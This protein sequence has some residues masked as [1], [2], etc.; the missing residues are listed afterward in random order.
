[1]GSS[2]FFLDANPAGNLGWISSTPDLL[3][4]ETTSIQSTDQ[5]LGSLA[6]GNPFSSSWSTFCVEGYNYL[7]AYSLPG[8]ANPRRLSGG[9]S[10]ISTVMPTAAT[11][12]QPTLSPVQQVSV[13]GQPLV[14]PVSG[15]G[16]API[17]AW[18]KPALGTPSF[19]DIN[20]YR[21]YNPNN[22]QPFPALQ[23]VGFYRVT[24]TTLQL[25]LGTLIQGETYALRIRAF[26]AAYKDS[27]PFR[28]SRTDFAYAD[29][30]TFTFQP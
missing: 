22:G 6:F 10:V 16:V 2:Y 9:I 30:M 23:Q 19:Y 26:N 17:I 7:V 8:M 24:A 27:E 12:I 4:M 1:M 29:C 11:P 13:G 14:G 5:N 3:V 25:P 21:F 18:Q 28:W 15:T 20:L